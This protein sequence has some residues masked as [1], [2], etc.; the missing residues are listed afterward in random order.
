[1]VCQEPLEI[2]LQTGKVRYLGHMVHVPMQK[3]LRR[4]HAPSFEAFD[5]K[6]VLRA[7]RQR[8]DP[9]PPLDAEG[10]SPRNFMSSQ[11]VA[12]R[13]RSPTAALMMIAT[14][15][16]TPRRAWRASTTGGKR[17]LLTW[18]WRACARRWSLSACSFTTRTYA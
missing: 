12:K 3:G 18:S 13:V 17:H 16:G 6:A 10:I 11:G 7:I 14:G 5:S 15:H 1:M 9:L 2:T 4:P 8:E